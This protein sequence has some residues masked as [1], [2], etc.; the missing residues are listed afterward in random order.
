[1]IT[2][3]PSPTPEEPT[4]EALAV[5]LERF[6]AALPMQAPPLTARAAGIL[7][8]AATAL[9]ALADKERMLREADAAL[10]HHFARD[11]KNWDMLETLSAACDRHAQRTKADGGER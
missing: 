2:D 7:K 9:R 5:E 11:L 10:H 6:R 8:Q 1:M 4:A 3:K